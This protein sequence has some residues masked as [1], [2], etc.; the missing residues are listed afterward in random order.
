MITEAVNI[1]KNSGSIDYARRRMQ[2]IIDEAWREAEKELPDNA[3][4]E[5]LKDLAYF[6]IQ[7]KM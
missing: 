4:R 5:C 6:N 7:R 1:I 3:Y 2:Q